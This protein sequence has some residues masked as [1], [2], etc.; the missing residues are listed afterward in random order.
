MK[1]KRKDFMAIL[2]AMI[3]SGEDYYLGFFNVSYEN[4]ET[5]E[6]FLFMSQDKKRFVF[7]REPEKD[8]ESNL[9]L[10]KA[11]M[12]EMY[13]ILKGSKEESLTVSMHGAKVLLTGKDLIGTVEASLKKEKISYPQNFVASI[14]KDIREGLGA[15][16]LVE[17]LVDKEAGNIIPYVYLKVS[18]ENT[19]FFTFNRWSATCY[20]LAHMPSKNTGLYKYKP[21]AFYEMRKFIA[22]TKEKKIQVKIFKNGDVRLATEHTSFYL[23]TMGKEKMELLDPEFFLNALKDTETEIFF[24]RESMKAALNKIPGLG[25]KNSHFVSIK[26]E[27][28]KLRIEA[29]TEDK[30]GK[31][32][33]YTYYVDGNYVKGEN[34]VFIYGKYLKAFVTK[35]KDE[36]LYLST[37]KE[38]QGVILAHNE[39]KSILS[40]S[41]DKKQE[42]R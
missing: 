21:Q 28:E 42:A 17:T 24:K 26:K 4:G 20:K 30:D 1:L 14:D 41:M 35:M 16:S 22:D 27:E 7:S 8:L 37:A 9:F 18:S 32:T 33:F 31:K 15:M 36:T 29:A 39:K 2:K 5:E 3:G 6:H 11:Q 23:K 12:E 40:T 34:P 19:F 10:E 13:E 25:Q 38:L